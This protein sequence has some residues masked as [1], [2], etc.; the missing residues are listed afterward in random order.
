[1]DWDE[2]LRVV[3]HWYD[4]AVEAARKPSRPERVAALK[5]LD[6]DLKALGTSAKMDLIGAALTLGLWP[7][8]KERA[9][10]KL[11]V[12]I[13]VLATGAA[14][15]AGDRLV[16]LNEMSRTVFALAA[17]RAKHKEY[18]EKLVDL[19]PKYLPAVP[20]DLFAR[21]PLRY[22]R[23]ASGYV[24]YSVGKNAKDDGGRDYH[25]PASTESPSLDD[26][27]IRMPVNSR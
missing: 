5:R 16:V 26:V 14:V 13:L 21:A 24:L 3:N 8:I 20:H 22:R 18:P 1:M 27:V 7:E 15:E 6:D 19:A 11:F 10:G 4:R 23:E 9:F 12:L 17:Y 25:S 2:I